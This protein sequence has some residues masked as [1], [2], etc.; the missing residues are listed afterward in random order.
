[1]APQFIDVSPER[2]SDEIAA[3]FSRVDEDGNGNLDRGEFRLAMTMILG[4]RMKEEE[5]DVLLCDFDE[6]GNGLISPQEFEHLVRWSLKVPCLSSCEICASQLRKQLHGNL[7]EPEPRSEYQPAPPPIS[8]PQTAQRIRC[9]NFELCGVEGPLRVVAAHELDCGLIRHTGHS[10]SGPLLKSP[11]TPQSHIILPPIAAASLSPQVHLGLQRLSSAPGPYVGSYFGS[12]IDG[13][14]NGVTRP[15]HKSTSGEGFN[16]APRSL[17]ERNGLPSSPDNHNQELFGGGEDDQR[18]RISV[19]A[20]SN[21]S[22]KLASPNMDMEAISPN[23]L[24]PASG[25]FSR[26][27]SESFT[28]TASD[29]SVHSGFSRTPS[30]GLGFSRT[31]SNSSNKSNESLSQAERVRKL[32]LLIS[33]RIESIS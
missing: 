15:I 22:S 33:M 29:S 21:F 7:S 19:R 20:Q 30:A 12:S 5:V 8:R 31:A 9:K 4:R 11:K 16:S 27:P 24:Q 32:G 14:T 17:L 6:D 28:R 2:L 18:S 10:I 26:T 23:F 1:M 25:G 3:V 13:V